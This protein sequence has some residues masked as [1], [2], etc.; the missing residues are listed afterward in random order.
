LGPD[1][2]WYTFECHHGDR[3]G[4]FG[5]LRLFSVDD[6]HDDATLEHLSHAALDAR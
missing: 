5:D 6:I 2:G 3:T 4:I 1:V